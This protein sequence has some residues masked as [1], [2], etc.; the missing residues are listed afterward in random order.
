METSCTAQVTVITHATTA[1]RLPA[2]RLDFF[3]ISTK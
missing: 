2:T 3:T 1:T